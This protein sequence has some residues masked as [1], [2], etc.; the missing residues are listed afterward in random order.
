M[1]LVTVAP[2]GVGLEGCVRRAA[3][4]A[5]EER[6]PLDS[7]SRMKALVAASDAE[8]LGGF[9]ALCMGIFVSICG[10]ARE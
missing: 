10:F 5:A 2:T 6:E 8:A 7:R 9:F 1:R 4:A 3:A